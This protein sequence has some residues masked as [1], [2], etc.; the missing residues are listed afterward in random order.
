MPQDV[1]IKNMTEKLKRLRGDRSQ[2]EVAEGIGISTSAYANY[3]AGIRVPRDR[4][5]MRIA[6][7]YN[8]SVS[9]IFYD[10]TDTKRVL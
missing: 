9:F 5:K 6:N 10:F 8:R 1:A 2:S 3:E 7:Y 4:I